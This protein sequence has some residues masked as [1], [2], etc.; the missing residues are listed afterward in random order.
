MS[1]LTDLISYWNCDESSGDLSDLFGGITLTNNGSTS[2]NTGKIG[3][4][5]DFGTTNTNKYFAYSSTNIYDGGAF[6]V[7]AWVKIRTAPSTGETQIIFFSIDSVTDTYPVLAYR[8]NGGTLETYMGRSRF[9]VADDVVTHSQDLG[10]SDWHMLTVS[11]DGTNISSYI[12]NVLV[13]TT[14]STGN[15]SGSST[16]TRIGAWATG[17][18]YLKAYVD[19]VGFWGRELTSDERN[20]LYNNGN[21]RQYPFLESGLL[22]YWKLNESSGNA[23]EEINSLTGT[24]Q[25]VTYSTGKINNGAVFNGTTSSLDIGTST[26]LKPTS[27]TLSAWIKTSGTGGAI[28][29]KKAFSNGGHNAYDI[30][31]SGANITSRVKRNSGNTFSDLT[32]SGATVNDDSWH[33]IV[34]T[35]TAGTHKIYIDNVERGSS[36]PTATNI[37]YDGNYNAFIG[38]GEA[39]TTREAFFTGTIDEVG[40][41]DRVLTISEIDELYNSGIGNEYPFVTPP[42]QPS[43]P[44]FFQLF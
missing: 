26:I 43:N 38:C 17:G 21:A 25:N 15:G 37:Y 1:L 22:A 13:G 3:N 27:V 40:I 18:D 28:V 33:H 20:K 4:S 23:S 5:I 14:T 2:F 10:T 29:L 19:M 36:S 12:D 16:M 30:S 9:G 39:G 11:Y 7:N 35:Y 8:N 24:N 41:W 32:S 34:M 44:N 6:T 31:I 42:P